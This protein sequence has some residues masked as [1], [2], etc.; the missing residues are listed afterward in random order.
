MFIFHNYF[1]IEHVDYIYEYTDINKNKAMWDIGV[2]SSHY[3]Q[4]AIKIFVRALISIFCFFLINMFF[5]PF[6]ALDEKCATINLSFCLINRES[7][8]AIN[9]IYPHIALIIMC[10][11]IKILFIFHI[12]LENSWH[13]VILTLYNFGHIEHPSMH[14]IKG[15]LVL[16]IML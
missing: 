6:N 2:W 1:V 9:Y 14:D 7:R 12:T 8:Q 15:T 16:L 5:N 4:T 3:G 11:G 10:F 13:D